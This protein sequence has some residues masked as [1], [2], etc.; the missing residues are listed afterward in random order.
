MSIKRQ[1]EQ[2]GSN[3]THDLIVQLLAE[4]QK[5]DAD[6]RQLLREIV[7]DELAKS[8]SELRLASCAIGWTASNKLTIEMKE[9]ASSA[10]DAYV[11]VKPVFDQACEDYQVTAKAVKP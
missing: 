9:Y 5:A 7:R 10:N 3:S 2:D 1:A 11:L 4:R 6:L 8:L